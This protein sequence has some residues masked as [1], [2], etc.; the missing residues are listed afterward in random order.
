MNLFGKS[1]WTLSTLKAYFESMLKEVDR[2]YEQRFEASQKAIDEANTQMLKRFDGVNEF[3]GAMSDSQAKYVTKGD[4]V[5]IATIVGII[6]TILDR[7]LN[8]AK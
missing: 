4:A 5:A 3:R 1:E 6:F 2:R 7:F 8:H